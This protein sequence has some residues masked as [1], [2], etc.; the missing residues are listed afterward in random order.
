MDLIET[1]FPV[2]KISWFKVIQEIL[3]IL[4][5]ETTNNLKPGNDFQ[6]KKAQDYGAKIKI[7]VKAILWE[8]FLFQQL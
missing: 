5:S 7:I 1:E 4:A 2:E 3:E 6:E 8:S